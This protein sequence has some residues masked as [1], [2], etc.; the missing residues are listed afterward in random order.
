MDFLHA[1]IHRVR[2]LQLLASWRSRGMPAVTVLLID[3]P[4][5]HDQYFADAERDVEPFILQEARWAA[6]VRL[7]Q[8]CPDHPH[9]FSVGE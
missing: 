5:C 1:R 8:E 3:C 9:R 2:L 6:R 4:R 7:A